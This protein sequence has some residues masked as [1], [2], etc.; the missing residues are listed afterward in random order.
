MFWGRQSSE[1]RRP[2]TTKNVTDESRAATHTPELVPAPVDGKPRKRVRKSVLYFLG[3]DSGL[4][5][6][7]GFVENRAPIGFEDLT[8]QICGSAV[9]E[10][11]GCDDRLAGFLGQKFGKLPDGTAVGTDIMDRVGIASKHQEL[12]IHRIVLRRLG[13]EQNVARGR[14][15]AASD[16]NSTSIAPAA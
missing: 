1:N 10:L 16:L 9:P 15:V 11:K 3:L 2:R 13:G 8:S 7:I 14:V 4:P 6:E 12:T 5:T